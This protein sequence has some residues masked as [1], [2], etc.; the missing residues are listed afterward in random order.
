MTVAELIAELQKMPQEAL[1]FV[2]VSCD[3]DF[4]MLYDTDLRAQISPLE[5]DA[6]HGFW[7]QQCLSDGALIG[8]LIS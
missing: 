4:A 2:A 1:A 3:D 7:C 6:G 5:F 8:V